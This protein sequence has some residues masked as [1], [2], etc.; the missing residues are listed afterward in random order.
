MAAHNLE[1]NLAKTVLSLSKRVESLLVRQQASESPSRILVALAG[2]PGSGK[3]TVSQ[4]LLSRLAMDGI[5][6]VVIVPMVC[7]P[8][9]GPSHQGSTN[10]RKDGFH[11][12]KEVLS[13]F[14][15]PAN[16]FKRRGTPFTFDAV[17]FLQLV[18]DIKRFPLTGSEEAEQFLYAPSFDHAIQ[19]PVTKGIPVSSRSRVVIVEGNYVLLNQDPWREVAAFCEEKWFVDASREM[20]LDRLV[21]RHIAAGIETDVEKSVERV[22]AN[23]LV[24]GDLIRSALI[25]P[26]VV[27]KN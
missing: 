11:H 23:D 4:A 14:P 5:T 6:D 24:N 2:V 19:D 7:Y 10:T 3:S 16:A 15:D 13:T 22:K 26:D 1:D 20:V 27:V 9:V 25:P 17:A 21:Q 12:T 18:K 8:Y